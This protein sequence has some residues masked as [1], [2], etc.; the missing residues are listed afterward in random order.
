MKIK[1][2]ID[3]SKPVSG[4][5]Y[6]VK[7][8]LNPPKKVVSTGYHVRAEEWDST[9]GQCKKT[10]PNASL[11][12]SHIRREINRYE[13]NYFTRGDP[14][15]NEEDVTPT[16]VKTTSLNEFLIDYKVELAKGRVT[17]KEGQPLSKHTLKSMKNSSSKIQAYLKEFPSD[18]NEITE[19][20]YRDFVSWLRY[21]SGYGDNSI[22]RIIKDLKRLLKVARKRKL[23]D[24]TDYEDFPAPTEESQGIALTESEIESMFL[25]ELSPRLII[26]RDRFYTAYNFLLRFTDSVEIDRS[27]I[28]KEGKKYFLNTIPSKTKDRVIIPLLPRTYEILKTYGFKFP[29]TT[30]QESNRHLKTIGELSKIKS[31]ITVFETRKGVRKK[32]QY[33]KW[34]LITTHTARRSMATNLWNNGFSLPEIMLLGGWKT[35][36]QLQKYLKIDKM[37]NAKKAANRK[38]FK[39]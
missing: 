3:K 2:I 6:T 15:K 27:D 28:V 35:L 14:F 10:R 39:G 29:K 13:E 9:L 11:I 25:P 32:I 36:T 19:D 34:E 24:S 18:F 31:L 30:N 16:L 4:G 38:F 12:N 33:K 21:E 23:H 20:F 22:G 26:E 17:G 8:Y 37:D 5:E 7:I 1:A